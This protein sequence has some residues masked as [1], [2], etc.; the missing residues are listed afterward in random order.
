M[1]MLVQRVVVVHRDQ[2]VQV[3]EC[4]YFVLCTMTATTSLFLSIMIMTLIVPTTI[5]TFA[6]G[7]RLDY[8]N[9]APGAHGW[10]YRDGFMGACQ[11]GNSYDFC[12][13]FTEITQ[14]QEQTNMTAGVSITDDQDNRYYEGFDWQGVCTN[15]LARNYIS[16]PCEQL[17]T[18]DGIALTSQGKQS[19]ENLLCPQG[20]SI[21]STIELFYGQIPDNLK[22]ELANA[23][24]WT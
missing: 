11:F 24:G 6:G 19:M 22:N 18:P 2:I 8:S 23:C 1:I 9:E 3:V 4:A 5:D 16:Q 20:P 13:S 10:P 15:P 7:P 21:L 14:I 12:S 17:V